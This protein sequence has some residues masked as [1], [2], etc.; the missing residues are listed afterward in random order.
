M[1][2]GLRRTLKGLGC[3]IVLVVVVGFDLISGAIGC[4]QVP[5]RVRGRVVDARTGAPV[6]GAALLTLMDPDLVDDPDRLARYWRIARMY[7]DGRGIDDEPLSYTVIGSARTGPDGSF[8]FP[9]G[10][11]TSVRTSRSGITWSRTRSD[12]YHVVRGLLVEADGYARLVHRTKHA[13]WR[14]QDVEATG[15]EIVGTFDVGTIRLEPRA[16]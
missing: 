13:T 7:E 2:R 11:S 1:R 4:G 10:L 6:E 5:M 3:S 14:E 15:G 16:R 9:V 12:P 8:E